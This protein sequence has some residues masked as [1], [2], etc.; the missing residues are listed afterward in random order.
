[1]S[2]K[3]LGCEQ[4]PPEPEATGTHL[5]V[6]VSAIRGHDVH[7]AHDIRPLFQHGQYVEVALRLRPAGRRRSLGGGWR[8]VVTGYAVPPPVPSQAPLA[9]GTGGLHLPSGPSAPIPEM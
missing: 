5:P 7:M 8:A 2:I 3:G 6:P 1:M 4:A 9:L